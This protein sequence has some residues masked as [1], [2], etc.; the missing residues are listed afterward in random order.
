[1]AGPSGSIRARCDMSRSLWSIPPSAD[2]ALA[3]SSETLT[4]PI[5]T[6]DRPLVTFS[7][8]FFSVLPSCSDWLGHACPR[9]PGPV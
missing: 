6:S 5:K 4:S 8:F 9:L 3:N 7:R 2:H 1:M